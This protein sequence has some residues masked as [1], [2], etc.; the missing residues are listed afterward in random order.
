[1]AVTLVHLSRSSLGDDELAAAA[2]SGGLTPH[3]RAYIERL[4]ELRVFVDLAHIAPRGFWDARRG[5]RPQPAAARVRIPASRGVHP[6]WRNLDDAQL[7]AVA[8]TGGVVGVI[9][10]GGYLGGGYWSG[11]RAR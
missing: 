9:F 10:H 5:P 7:A 4:N 8:D 1:M 6:H 3:G 2:A 11:G